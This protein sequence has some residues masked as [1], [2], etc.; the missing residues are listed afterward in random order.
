M[1][2]DF[3][4]LNKLN[5]T[6]SSAYDLLFF[7]NLKPDDLSRCESEYFKFGESTAELVVKQLKNDKTQIN[8]NWYTTLMPSSEGILNNNFSKNTTTIGY[9]RNKGIVMHRYRDYQLK[10]IYWQVKPKKNVVN[11]KK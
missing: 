3:Q 11:R 9:I 6:F 1:P 5:F 7:Q 8:F 10:K 2:F 4:D